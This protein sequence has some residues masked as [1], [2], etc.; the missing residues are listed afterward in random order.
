MQTQ[1]LAFIRTVRKEEQWILPKNQ[2]KKKKN[3]EQD[4]KSSMKLVPQFSRIIATK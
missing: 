1:T 3:L 4:P 2:K